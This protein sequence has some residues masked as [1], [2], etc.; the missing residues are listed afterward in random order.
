[1]KITVSLLGELFRYRWNVPVL[2]E[3]RR[4]EGS[5]YVTLMHRLAVSDGP[6]RQTLDHLT[7]QGWVQRNPGYGHPSR[8]EYILT[9][10]A[11]PLADR[12]D[13]TLQVLGEVDAAR[14]GLNR[15]T[16]T[17]LYR[18]ATGATRFGDLRS[19]GPSISPRALTQ[20]LREMMECD[21]VTRHVSDE[22][23]VTITYALTDAGRQVAGVW[24][25]ATG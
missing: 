24:G 10:D 2:A 23:P 11:R 8:P 7:A 14:V 9:D 1:L 25:A 5:K 12:C 21:L 6:L 15:W 16:V 20:A 18:L 17:I 13:L 4:S 22:M 3:L 19:E